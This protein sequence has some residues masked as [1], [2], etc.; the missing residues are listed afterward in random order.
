MA[1][2]LSGCTA[3]TVSLKWKQQLKESIDGTVL[4]LPSGTKCLCL[5]EWPTFCMDLTSYITKKIWNWFSAQLQDLESK[6]LLPIYYI[7]VLSASTYQKTTYLSYLRFRRFTIL[8]EINEQW[9][10]WKMLKKVMNNH[11]KIRLELRKPD[12]IQ[13]WN[14]ILGHL[15]VFSLHPYS[16]S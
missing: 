2:T 12:C 15:F 16:S 5:L 11:C 10:V 4:S 1:Q 8:S 9:K 7:P 13:H 6:E 14:N 3:P